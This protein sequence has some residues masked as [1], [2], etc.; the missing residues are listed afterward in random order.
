[1]TIKNDVETLKRQMVGVQNDLD[2]IKDQLKNI[3]DD[4][5]E[6][7]SEEDSNEAALECDYDEQMMDPYFVISAEFSSPSMKGSCTKYFGDEMDTDQIWW[8][9]SELDSISKFPRECDARDQ[10]KLLKKNRKKMKDRYGESYC[11]F[12]YRIVLTNAGELK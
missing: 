7:G 6:D 11:I 1:M 5:E 9:G 12:N 2:T 4:S 8:S 10:M 3:I